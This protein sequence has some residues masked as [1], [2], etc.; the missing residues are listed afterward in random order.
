MGILRSIISIRRFLREGFS[1]PIVGLGLLDPFSE[2]QPSC[3]NCPELPLWV[4]LSKRVVL[5]APAV[6]VSSGEVSSKFL[7]PHL[8]TL[9]L[10]EGNVISN[11]TSLIIWKRPGV[12]VKEMFIISFQIG[13][14]SLLL[15]SICLVSVLRQ[16]RLV[17][18]STKG[19]GNI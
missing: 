15:L 19:R 6:A 18:F 11:F 12:S 10:L 7:A 9:F 5:N 1:F 14:G 17:Y 2:R 4:V 8:T 3:L 16:V 13:P